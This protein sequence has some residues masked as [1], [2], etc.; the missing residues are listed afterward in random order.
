MRGDEGYVRKRE[1][2]YVEGRRRIRI[3]KERRMDSVTWGRGISGEQTQNR[4][5]WRQLRRVIFQT[6]TTTALCYKTFLIIIIWIHDILPPTSQYADSVT[7][8]TIYNHHRS[9]L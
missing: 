4:A 8:Q 3:L 5:V 2:M 1:R 7:Q 9:A 6:V